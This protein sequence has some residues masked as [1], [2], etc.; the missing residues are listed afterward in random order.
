VVVTRVV[1]A[2]KVEKVVAVVKV[3]AVESAAENA[4]SIL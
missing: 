4:S 2:A 1:V 3:V